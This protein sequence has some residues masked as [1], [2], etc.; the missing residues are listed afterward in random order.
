MCWIYR[1]AQEAQL[2]LIPGFKTLLF[3]SLTS[4]CYFI[5]PVDVCDAP[6]QTAFFGVIKYFLVDIKVIF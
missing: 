4:I 1:E 3:L 2:H 5:C 6:D